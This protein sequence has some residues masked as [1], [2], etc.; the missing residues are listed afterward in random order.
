MKEFLRARGK[1]LRNWSLLG[2]VVIPFLLYGAAL[3]G[4]GWLVNVLLGLMGLAMLIALK[5]G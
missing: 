2:M 1:C 5:V 4:P 3:H